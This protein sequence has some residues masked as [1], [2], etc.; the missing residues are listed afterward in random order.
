MADPGVPERR[1]WRSRWTDPAVHDAPIRV[2]TIDR[3]PQQT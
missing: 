1:S 2:F 3:N